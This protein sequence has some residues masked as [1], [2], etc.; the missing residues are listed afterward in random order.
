MREIRIV[1][2]DDH[3]ILRQGLRAVLESEAGFRVLNEA[4]N[5]LDALHLVEQLAPDVLVADLIM[6]GLPGLEVVR[7]I[8]SRV[9]QTRVVIFSMHHNEEHVLEALR[10][11]AMGYV[12]K[13]APASEMIEAVREVAEGRRYLSRVLTERAIAAYVEKAESI[14]RDACDLLT[15]REREVLHLSAAGQSISEIAAQLFLSPRT[16]E[17]HRQSFMHKLGLRTQTDLI[18]YALRRGILPPDP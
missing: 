15:D 16:V 3:P 17:T 10:H 2:A 1:L 7:Q 8:A 9:P 12:V 6:P 4:S 5:G 11:G 13:D 18:R 14:A